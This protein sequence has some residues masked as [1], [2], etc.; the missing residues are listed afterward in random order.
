VKVIGRN[1]VGIVMR[2]VVKFF[3]PRIYML[4]DQFGAGPLQVVAPIEDCVMDPCGERY[5]GCRGE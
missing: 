1:E 2:K 5:Q 3:R 4:P